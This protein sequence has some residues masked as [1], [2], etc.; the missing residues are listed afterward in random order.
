MS[1][2]KASTSSVPAVP[3]AFVFE[4]FNAA[5]SNFDRW[6][7]RLQISFRI[8]KVQQED[9]RDYLLHYM[10][11]A[12]YDVLCNKLKT[13]ATHTKTYEE[14]VDILME[15]YSP[16]PLEIMECFKFQSRN[17]QEHESLSDFL[18]DLEKL[19]RSCNFEAYLEK[20]LRNQFVYGIRN[21]TIKSRLLE[22]RQLTLEKAKEIAFSMEMSYRG[23]D[24]MLVSRPK[25]EVQHI[26]HGYKK[27]KRPIQS[28]VPM[29]AESSQ[30]VS[31]SG[32]QE[33]AC[34]R[35][36]ETKHFA[37][38]CKYK[39]A[40][41]K[42]CKKKGH[43]EKV[44]QAKQ[45]ELKQRKDTHH[46]EEPSTIKEIFHIKAVRGL[47]GKFLLDLSINNKKLTFEIDTGSPVSLISSQDKHSHFKHCVLHP[48]D[49]RLVS[50]CDTNVRLLGKIFVKINSDGDELTLPL[51]VADSNRHPLLGRDWL[52][53][54]NLDFN[55]VFKPGVHSISFCTGFEPSTVSAL[56][57]LL[58]RY[59]RVFNEHVGKISGV[60]AS[61]NLRAEAKPVFVKSRP[62]A[63]AVR[64]AVDTE[65]DKL[66]NEGIWE[67][68]DHSEWATP[69][70]P[71]RKAGGK[72]RLCGDYK[73][74]LNPNLLIDDHP[75]PTADELFATVAGGERFSKIDL[76]QAYLQLEVKPEHR[77]LLTLSTHRGLF[78]PTRLMY[79]VAS[80]PAI[81]QRLME[82]ILQGI[83]GVT[84]F[85]DD[86]RVTGPDDRT[87]LLR[88]EE[89]FKRL[90]SHNM[91][92]NRSK[93]DFFSNKI[94]YCGYLVDKQGIHKIRKKIDAIQ[95]MPVPKNKEQ[96]R[97]FVGLVGY[98]GRFLPNQST[99]LYPLNNLLKEDVPFCWS[100]DCEKS[101]ALVKKEMQSNRFLVHY[102][103]S[104]PVV[105]AT[106]A[107][108]YGVGAVLS[109]QYP[110]GTE[111]PL[112]Y[113][114][115]TLTRTQQ[116]YSQI[117]KEAYAIIFGIR[118][119]HQ[120]VYGRKFILV[121]DNKPVSQIFSESKGLPAMSALHMQHY[122]AFLQAFDYQI[123]YR[124]SSDHCNADAMS[125][126]PLTVTDPKSE[127]DESDVVEVNSIQTL[128]LTVDELGCATIAD[129]SVKELI[130]ALRTGQSIDAKFRFGVHQEEFSLQKD[131]VMRGSRV[132]VPFALRARVLDELHSTHFGI[133]RIKSLAR[134]YC[135]W[136]GI[137]RDIEDLVK[138]CA[139]CQANKANPPKAA[140]HCWETPSEPFQRVH[141][142]YAGPFMGYYYLVLI[143]AFS[144]WPDVHVLKNMTTETTIRACREFF[145][146]YGIP[147]VFVSDNGPQFASVD[148][149][150]FIKLNGIVH[151]F[152]AP[153]H[154]ATNGQ[155]E[156]FIQT[157]KCK[158]KASVSNRSEINAELCNI[159][160]TY[161]KSVHPTTGYSPSMIVFGR[162]IRSRLDLMIPSNDPKASEIQGKIREFTVGSR[163]SAREYLHENKWEFGYIKERIGKLHYSVYLD[164][165]RVW[166]RHIDQLR[167]VGDG[168]PSSSTL[169]TFSRGDDSL[170]RY[171]DHAAAVPSN[172]KAQFI[173]SVPSANPNP[174]LTDP[175]PKKP[176]A[177]AAVPISKAS[178]SVAS[179]AGSAGLPPDQGLRRSSRTIQPP[180]K[181]DL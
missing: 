47:A 116:K 16:Q 26:E 150:K 69:V 73:I 172:S 4:P 155:A 33:K 117:D 38:K 62:V 13:E 114:S 162:Q 25:T 9:R 91:H 94:E 78:Q 98:Y 17:Q 20:A 142:D 2:E 61:L 42:Y 77:H 156:R 160:V 35:C 96:V 140:Y 71:V 177:G 152:S 79:G 80:A 72:V 86:I 109:H 122:A 167:S 37:D 23:T 27:K 124:R 166:R 100:K 154:P 89:V 92:V 76:S 164:D 83:P 178:T 149:A 131:C 70:V 14:I 170:C 108:P 57:T 153:Y 3:A 135:W 63:F 31:K 87:H 40:V 146:T 136:Q 110:D 56:K 119:F 132:Y 128:P 93:C 18:M 67:R 163:V 106:D 180:R 52:V 8:F 82:Q 137:D 5:T 19:A 97:S 130:R 107:S 173:P 65:I 171:D 143:D 55:R 139:S 64:E 175:T 129:N 32:A 28:Q 181:L 53:E 120:Y 10:G 48:T 7:E 12:T 36:G 49:M 68:V 51:H 118:K 168:L 34:Y 85:I 41:C 11:S 90:D 141:A 144:K 30:Q 113:A 111:R 105:L 60:Q 127:I 102:N 121:T 165:G 126:L 45:K 145:S 6:V 179:S 22:C 147:S 46:L 74:T 44:C 43:L 134:S 88:L 50:Y 59:S 75:L 103:P 138:D 157:M 99:I 54:L 29:Q 148:F 15:H 84:V 123:R 21:R 112:Q 161:R 1:R 101:F 58:E 151:K 24:E 176:L 169:E 115:Q 81:F 133:S 158:M 39:S 159:L 125:R 66:V 95:N 174:V 104:L